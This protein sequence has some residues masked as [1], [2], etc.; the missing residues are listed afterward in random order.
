LKNVNYTADKTVQKNDGDEFGVKFGDEF[1]VKFGVKLNATQEKILALM[2]S[3]A[4]IS[5]QQIS[6]I[7]GI[8]KRA[9]E[10]NINTL[11]L[12]GAI[13]REGSAKNGRWLVK[14]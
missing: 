3:D 10:K 8:T 12:I 4:T 9:I 5:I 2:L 6:E 7:V 13:K 14:S 11:K 1:G